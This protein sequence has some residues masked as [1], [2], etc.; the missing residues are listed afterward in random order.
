MKGKKF[1]VNKTN[2][3]KIDDSGKII[4]NPFALLLSGNVQKQINALKDLK[5]KQG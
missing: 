5:K 4:V 3:Y 1:V 2:R